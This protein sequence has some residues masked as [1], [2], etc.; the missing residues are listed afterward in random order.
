MDDIEWLILELEKY[1][2]KYGKNI[3][4]KVYCS[5]YDKQEFDIRY[6]EYDDNEKTVFIMC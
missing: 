6:L 2:N 1:K 4:V 5:D 3:E